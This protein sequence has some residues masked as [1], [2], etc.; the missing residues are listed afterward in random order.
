V[1]EGVT[2]LEGLRLYSESEAGSR[3]GPKVR[4]FFQL[5]EE[6][7]GDVRDAAPVH[8]LAS[9]LERSGYLAALEKDGSPEAEGRLEN[10]R[11]L[12]A[13]AEDFE[14]GGA[15]AP[16]DDRSEIEVFLDQVALVS[17]I[18]Q[19]DAREDCVSLMTVHSAKGLEYPVVYLVGMEE[20]IFPHSGALRDEDGIEEE[21]RL[22]YVGMTRAM[23]QLTICSAA[24]RMR[25][26]S[27][28]YGVP[29]RFLDEI[30]ES[31]VERTSTSGRGGRRSRRGAAGDSEYDYSY[32]QS[33][34]GEGGEDGI[35]RGMRVRHPHFGEGVVLTVS[36]SGPS[37]KLKVDFERAG[38]KTLMLKYASLEPC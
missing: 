1:R 20:G 11:E 26:G 23:E 35:V 8:A 28:N 17:D 2:L 13:A 16:D 18:D 22:C 9:V 7:E 10:L 21:R 30:P 15:A 3:T 12:L 4:R 25:F 6:L 24:E 31:A 14:R 33:T 32:A 37:Q 36:G 34:P 5:L 29:S 38:L 27:R 19:V